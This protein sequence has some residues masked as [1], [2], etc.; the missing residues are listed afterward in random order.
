M[1]HLTRGLCAF[2]VARSGATPTGPSAALVPVPPLSW[3][4]AGASSTGRELAAARS[5]RTHRSRFSP[6]IAGSVVP[7]CGGPCRATA[8]GSDIHFR[9]FQSGTTNISLRSDCY[10]LLVRD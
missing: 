6:T 9:V 8:L 1:R 3:S 2:T 4:V 5:S 7:S 10:P